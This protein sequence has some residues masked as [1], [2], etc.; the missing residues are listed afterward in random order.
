MSSPSRATILREHVTLS[1]AW[2]DPLY[3]NGYVPTLQTGGQLR[4]FLRDHLGFPVPLP[5]VV[6]RIVEPTTRV[7]GRPLVHRRLSLPNWETRRAESHGQASGSVA[8]HKQG[9]EPWMLCIPNAAESISISRR[10][11]R[12]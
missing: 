3:L 9:A 4:T 2:L 7:I 1:A 10:L 11:W 6:P 5:A 12:A 8:N